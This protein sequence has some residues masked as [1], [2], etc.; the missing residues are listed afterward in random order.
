MAGSKGNGNSS[1]TNCCFNKH[2]LENK[3]TPLGKSEIKFGGKQK[4]V[5]ELLGSKSGCA[6]TDHEVQEKMKKFH[7][8]IFNM[9]AGKYFTNYEEAED[10][11]LKRNFPDVAE[12]CQASAI[13]V[14]ETFLP[15]IPRAVD[16]KEYV[17]KCQSL[18]DESK[19]ELGIKG[20]SE[21]SQNLSGDITEKELSDALKK[22]YSSSPDKQVTI[23]QGA[24]FKPPGAKKGTNQEHDF[25]I[26]L[27]VLKCIICIESKK[28][29]NG[30]SV[31]GG[32]KQLEGMEKLIDDYFGPMSG[33]SYIAWMHFQVNNSGLHIC[34]E[35]EKNIIF[36]EEDLHTMLS[37]LYT[38]NQ[39]DPNHDEYKTV[40][41]RIAFSLL[42][43]DIGTPC[44]IASMVDNKV[45]GRGDKQ[46]QGDFKSFLFWSLDQ[47]NLILIHYYFVLFTSSWSTGKTLCMREKA[48]RCA[49]E[50]PGEEIFF[51]VCRYN[52][53]KKTLL[54]M[55]LEQ[56][57]SNINSIKV[58]N[59][60]LK[61]SDLTDL[62][63][64]LLSLVKS[65]PEAAFFVDE[66][67]L[68]GDML[69]SLSKDLSQLVNTLTTG[70]G[71]L[72]MSIA[73]YEG[74]IPDMSTI[75]SSFSMFHLPVMSIPLRSTR[76]VL[77]MAGME[78]GSSSH[79]LAVAETFQ[80]SASYTLPPLLL[81]GLPGTVVRVKEKNNKEEVV[82]AVKAA[83][84]KMTL[85]I[86]V[87]GVLVLCNSYGDSDIF[88]L[89]REGLLSARLTKVVSYD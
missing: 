47:A 2:N 42:S 67:V 53:G 31:Q 18:D 4:S 79:N 70:G 60:N 19:K 49:V 21:E 86:G 78:G 12:D 36:T 14:P 87:R 11:L 20:G 15:K 23:F 35:C 85:R 75:Q 62:G 63:P 55:E 39:A 69:S 25:L 68:P 3:N 22:F 57:F 41:K 56:Q 17:T 44:T 16:P 45:V 37:E 81:P 51:I 82:E 65:N 26:I 5:L 28:S 32:L 24:V 76:Q 27:K 66:A 6:A 1:K 71:M 77:A 64:R 80:T 88:S 13:F 34:E 52:C 61:K 8:Y 50:R 74:G 30:K 89:V 10:E 40:V 9:G 7:S 59:F 29:L 83:R 38:T 72:W 73:G 46:G 58:I 54:E 84:E 43:Q 48:K 33:W